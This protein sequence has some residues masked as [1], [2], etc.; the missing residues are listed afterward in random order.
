L[1]N[2]PP[3]KVKVWGKYALFTRPE[4]KVERVSYPCITPSAARGVLESIF[5]KPEIDWQVRR[6]RVLKPIRFESIMRNEV[7]GIIPR[8]IAD[9][10]KGDYCAD[11][12]RQQRNSLFLRDVA[13]VIEADILLREHA[14]QDVA[15]YRDMFRR[16]VK[17]GQC[18][19]QPYLGTRECMGF[20][21][22]LPFSF[23][24][25]SML[26]DMKYPR[27]GSKDQI[28]IPIFFQARIDHGVLEVPQDLYKEVR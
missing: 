3:L 6:I 15:K 17:K 18:F 12:D 24:L 23:H 2:Y 22:A 21:G 1:K 26:F 14:D 9:A 27:S 4:G 20:F 13:Y 28:A 19:N 25:G 16:R 5:W 7:E 10:T 11:E 8:T